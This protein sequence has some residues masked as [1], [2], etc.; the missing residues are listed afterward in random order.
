[1]TGYFVR[2]FLLIIPTF[3]GITH[4]RFRGHAFRSGR[5]G[6]TPDHALP[7]GRGDR[8][9]RRRPRHESRFPQEAIEEM[10]R[11]YGFDKPVHIRYAHVAL[12]CPA[13]RS[14]ALL[15]LPGPGLGRHQV[16]VSHF[17]FPGPDRIF[18]E[19]PR[20][21]SAGRLQGD[22]ARLALRSR[23]QPDRVPGLLHSRLGAGHGA[24]GAVRRRQLLESVSARRLPSRQLGI[25]R[26]SFRRSPRR[27]TTC[28]CRC[29]AT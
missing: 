23:Q 10:Q 2:R 22:P 4:G 15:H 6:R 21:H 8:R 25:P 27:S 11:Y 14:R 18:P 26:A 19:L 1:M 29:S 24:A 12:E 5:P 28:F 9:R 17:D 13:P 16:A 7:D 20:L 3:I